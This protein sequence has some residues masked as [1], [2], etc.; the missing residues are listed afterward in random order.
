MI[1]VKKKRFASESFLYQITGNPT[2]SE[3]RRSLF[4]FL[5]SFLFSFQCPGINLRPAPG[6]KSKKKF[7]S[8]QQQQKICLNIF[9]DRSRRVIELS[10]LKKHFPFYL[11]S[12]KKKKIL[13]FWH[14]WTDLCKHYTIAM[15]EILFSNRTGMTDEYLIYGAFVFTSLNMMRWPPFSVYTK[16]ELDFLSACL[17]ILFLPAFTF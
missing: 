15:W 12:K 3:K 2:I 10:F 17:P 7:I 8:F 5:L 9:A 4:F 1:A 13:S 11:S 6:Q 14:Y 16:T